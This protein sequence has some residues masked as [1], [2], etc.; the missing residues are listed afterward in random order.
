MTTPI[1]ILASGRSAAPAAAVLL[2]FD[3]LLT[4]GALYPVG[5]V[6][7]GA[8]VTAWREAVAPA[9]GRSVVIEAA[10]GDLRILGEA[11]PEGRRGR[12]R[13]L[14]LWDKLGL[15]S[16]RI[17][18][19]A[20]EDALH[21]LAVR[22]LSQRREADA[23]GHLQ[24]A[25]FDGLAETVTVTA[26]TFRRRWSDGID[27]ALVPLLEALVQDVVGACG[28]AETAAAVQGTLE[29]MFRTF[30]ADGGDGQPAL[31]TPGDRILFESSLRD[32]P[33]LM[34]RALRAIVEREGSLAGF[35]DA[36]DDAHEALA[37]AGAQR[38]LHLL[39]EAMAGP[40]RAHDDEPAAMELR[41][42]D[43]DASFRIPLAELKAAFANLETACGDAAAP[44]G[45][46]REDAAVCLAVL[47]LGPAPGV[48]RQALAGLHHAVGRARSL[49]ERE[50]LREM[51]VALVDAGDPA[52]ADQVLPRLAVPFRDRGVDDVA[53]FWYSLAAG[54]PERAALVWPHAVIEL[55]CVDQETAMRGLSVLQSLATGLEPERM[56]LEAGRFG[57]LA[58]FVGAAF[59]KALFHRPRPVMY[60]VYAA[61]LQTPLA[62]T[63]AGWLQEGWL[64]LPADSAGGL[65]A[66]AAGPYRAGLRD[67]YRDVLAHG[68]DDADGPPP[69]SLL[70]TARHAVEQLPPDRRSEAWVP[71]AL[72]VLGRW[73]AAASRRLLERVLGERRW[74]VARAWPAPCRDAARTALVSSDTAKERP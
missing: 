15:A 22:L 69:R 5:H 52:L 62:D 56:L 70:E 54:D 44:A 1:D 58:G 38:A 65:A 29:R 4:A 48:A 11:V 34:G 24:E 12:E 35:D 71:V 51:A 64:R 66:R 72:L 45:D 42:V 46:L 36:L 73:H 21:E 50:H 43:D 13:V 26:R 2:A 18:A 39:L 14:G 30:L 20:A 74:L 28:D 25:D 7:F 23:S 27:A 19:D 63:F 6:N 57:S 10:G 41:C 53:D 49:P 55:L 3:R 32:D 17:D 8:A 61:L 47:A 68:R 67:L 60:G 59:N 16:V 40:D 31:C 37:S 33:G 9:G